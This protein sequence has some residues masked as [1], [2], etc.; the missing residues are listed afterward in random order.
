MAF[1]SFIS[2]PKTRAWSSVFA[3][4][5]VYW[6]VPVTKLL[7]LSSDRAL[8]ICSVIMESWPPYT[9]LFHREYSAGLWQ[10]KA[11]EEHWRRNGAFFLAPA[12]QSIVGVCVLGYLG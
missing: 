12:T 5:F 6:N 1:R 8:S 9:F 7:L 4:N 10:K 2:L 3:L 11:L